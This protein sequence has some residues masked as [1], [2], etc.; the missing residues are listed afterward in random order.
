MEKHRH[1]RIAW[2]YKPARRRN[3][4]RPRMLWNFELKQTMKE[5]E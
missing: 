5:D 3:P 2:E 1:S 4:R